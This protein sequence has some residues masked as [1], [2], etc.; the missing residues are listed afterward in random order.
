L[1]RSRN[2]LRRA[3]RRIRGSL[4]DHHR[5]C[6]GELI[7]QPRTLE[8][9]VQHGAWRCRAVEAGR[10]ASLYQRWVVQ[11]LQAALPGELVQRR[12]QRT[13]GDMEALRGGSSLGEYA[14]A[15]HG[16]RQCGSKQRD[17]Q[18]LAATMPVVRYV[19]IPSPS[20]LSCRGPSR[21]PMTRTTWRKETP[22]RYRNIVWPKSTWTTS[23]GERNASR[24]IS[25]QCFSTRDFEA[26]L[27]PTCKRTSTAIQANLAI[28][29]VMFGANRINALQRAHQGTRV[30][31]AELA[32]DLEL[33]Q[34]RI[35]DDQAIGSV[36]VGLG[37]G[38]A[39]RR[40]S[41]YQPALRPACGHGWIGA[42]PDPDSV[43]C[44]DLLTSRQLGRVAVACNRN[45]AFKHRDHG[46]GTAVAHVEA[47]ADIGDGVAAGLHHE[48]TIGI[49]GHLEHRLTPT[50]PYASSVPTEIDIKHGIGVEHDPGAVRQHHA[51]LFAM[52]RGIAAGRAAA[53]K[54]P[55]GKTATQHN[56]CK[57]SDRQPTQATVAAGS[58]LCRSPGFL[59]P[60]H[61]LRV[62]GELIQS[63][64]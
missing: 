27:I 64:P 45:R 29:A 28:A 39:E 1:A 26:T 57:R 6:I 11:H 52:C 9:H 36:A 18:A 41:E 44:H 20:S 4:L 32:T 37:H 35:R 14:R 34:R 51:A 42:R 63:A 8:Q 33:R 43:A 38:V 56:G 13:T 46:L 24:W 48:R 16:G 47:R 25:V 23:D 62:L 7:D 49:V 10:G 40:G 31:N 12:A 21:V 19:H 54:P 55:G 53:N 22:S 5:S 2:W 15:Y 3:T 59:P 58:G 50:Q 30:A 60:L 61:N 17:A